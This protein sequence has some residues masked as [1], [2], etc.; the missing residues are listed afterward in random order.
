[1][2]DFISALDGHQMDDALLDVAEHNS[3]AW[4]VG[5]RNG[6]E[7]QEGDITFQNNSQYYA[8]L[9]ASQITGDITD[10]VRWDTD[11]STILTD[12][13][14][15]RARNNINA[16]PYND[17]ATNLNLLDNPWWGSAEVINQR[18][19]TSWSGIVN[20]KYTVDRWKC[21]SESSNN[22][23]ELRSEGIRFNL[24]YGSSN[25]LYTYQILSQPLFNSIKGKVATASVL[26]GNG[27]IKSGTT[28]IPSSGTATFISE[29]SVTVTINNNGEF[30]VRILVSSTIRA[31]KL[32]LCSWSTLAN[33]V[34]PDKGIELAKCI[35]STAD[36]S[37]S[38]ANS[39]YA[40]SNRN[41][42]D[43]PFF[44]VNQRSL[45]TYTL[46]GNAY[47][48]DRWKSSG[49]NT[50]TVSGNGISMASSTG[51]H[52]NLLQGMTTESFNGIAG[53]VLT[54]S[55]LTQ[56]GALSTLTFTMPSSIAS[57]SIANLGSMSIGGASFILY[58]GHAYSGLTTEYTFWLY[59]TTTAATV[60]YRAVKLELGSYSTLINDT[61]PDYGEELRKCR[62]Y[63]RRYAPN[64][65]GLALIGRAGS[66]TEA[67]FI[68]GD[69]P[70]AKSTGITAAI[71]GSVYARAGDNTNHS[72]TSATVQTSIGG[73]PALICTTTGLTAYATAVIVFASGGYIDINGD[74]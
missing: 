24:S 61:P 49:G 41:L 23:L 37:D 35:S 36:P 8:Q 64:Q 53:K 69:E 5:T 62:R 12:E 28:T 15:A 31:V 46:T 20:N 34:P 9:A 45:T 26:L 21:V 67:D 74:L 51:T 30:T 19:Q 1:M 44:T 14:K 71:N 32:E 55:V 50:I 73:G 16:A 27:T 39:G 17:V 42:L 68:L 25:F 7:V 29:G 65:T 56:S 33:D 40:R 47:I 10:A 63:F 58:F 18:G 2:A 13:A 72:V 38:Y 48:V 70:M 66:A 6:V 4:A 54:A 11:Q 3:E 43:N 59:S 57:G 22:S 52:Q 60:A